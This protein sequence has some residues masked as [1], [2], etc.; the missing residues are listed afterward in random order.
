MAVGVVV[1]GLGIYAFYSVAESIGPAQPPE[2]SP[3]VRVVESSSRD[4]GATPEGAEPS[5]RA[6]PDPV[7]AAEAEPVEEA[8]AQE[9]PPQ[10]KAA[11]VAPLPAPV[12]PPQ[13]SPPKEKPPV[14]PAPEPK[15]KPPKEPSGDPPTVI[16]AVLE[17]ADIEQIF[18][19]GDRAQAQTELDARLVAYPRDP[20]ALILSAAML[21]DRGQLDLA[22][23]AARKA[24]KEA[25]EFANAYAYLGT[26]LHESGARAEAMKA[27]QS[28]LDFAPEGLF[29]TSIRSLM[30]SARLEEEK[31]VAQE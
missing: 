1:F 20:E 25:P 12:V 2:R 4:S 5:G 10:G 28:Y 15:R 8:G 7:P 26:L 30:E 21:A 23:D 24:V 11:A 9:Q 29:A 6:Q 14:E 13:P 3:E 16:A 17:T 27:Y 18:S 31:G 19:R 22:L